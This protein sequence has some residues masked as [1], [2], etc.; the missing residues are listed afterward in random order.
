MDLMKEHQKREEVK[1]T[2]GSHQSFQV[3]EKG[4]FTIR[5]KKGRA[6]IF[7]ITEREEGKRAQIAGGHKTGGEGDRLK[8]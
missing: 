5:K 7:S 8:K 1:K 6:E 2:G 3:Q 4:I